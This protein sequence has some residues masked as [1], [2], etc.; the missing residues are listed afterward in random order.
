MI[1]YEID[2]INLSVDTSS[3]AKNSASE[4]TKYLL[5]LLKKGF[6]FLYRP[7]SIGPWSLPEFFEI[8]KVADKHQ[9]LVHFCLSAA[10]KNI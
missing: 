3:F 6:S 9:L 5:F 8:M 10:L 2:N 4:V 1:Y 7:Q